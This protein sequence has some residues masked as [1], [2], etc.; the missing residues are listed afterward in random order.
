MTQ[1]E[2]ATRLQLSGL[3][4][5]IGLLAMTV[6]AVMPLLNI[7]HEWMKWVFAIGAVTVLAGRIIGAYNGPQLRGKRHPVLRQRADDVSL[8]RHQR[9]DSPA[10]GRPDGA[11][12]RHVDDRTRKQ[13]NGVITTSKREIYFAV[14]NS[15]DNFAG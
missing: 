1:R 2:N 13:E 14:S 3:L 11:D 4:V 12:L 15:F 6:M 5:L 7:I 10:A 9:L 8:P